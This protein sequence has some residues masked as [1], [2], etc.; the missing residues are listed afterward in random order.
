M[1]EYALVYDEVK[2]EKYYPE[3]ERVMQ[4]MILK[5]LKE[6]DFWSWQDF[7]QNW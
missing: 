3:L 6:L 7:R 4:S 2:L 5:E 1:F